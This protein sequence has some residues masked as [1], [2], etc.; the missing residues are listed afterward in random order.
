MTPEQ[1]YAFAQQML[2]AASKYAMA[3][4]DEAVSPVR[5]VSIKVNPAVRNQFLVMAV[6]QNGQRFEGRIQG[7]VKGIEWCSTPNCNCMGFARARSRL[8]LGMTI[9]D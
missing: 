7:G 5:R 8:E 3:R 6:L 4:F 1:R 9:E 2:I